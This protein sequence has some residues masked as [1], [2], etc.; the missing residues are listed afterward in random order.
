MIFFADIGNGVPYDIDVEIEHPPGAAALSQR[1]A[2]MDLTRVDRDD[3]AR[4]RL[5]HAA[6]GERFLRAALHK[7]NAEL[8]VHVAWEDTVAIRHNRRDTGH[9]SFRHEE[10]TTAH[11]KPGAPFKERQAITGS[12][13]RTGTLTDACR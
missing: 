3:M 6:T 8:I 12:L 5:H 7:A 1:N 13:P 2:V 10:L 9:G 11:K 4:F